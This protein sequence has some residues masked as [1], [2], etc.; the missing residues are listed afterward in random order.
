MSIDYG[1][2]VRSTWGAAPDL[3]PYFGRV[4]GGSV[5]LHALARRLVTP[6]GSLPWAPEVGFDVRALQNAKID[7]SSRAQLQRIE[8]AV[9][10]QCL[11]DDRVADVD[12]DVTFSPSTS[13]LRISVTVQLADGSR[14]FTFV[15]LVSDAGTQLLA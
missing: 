12:V 3:D 2:G 13:T 7:T 5:V 4:T 8:S 9:R 10:G 14:P 6:I 15:L 1:T 11:D